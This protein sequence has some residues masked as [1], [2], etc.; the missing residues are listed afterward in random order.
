MNRR[1]KARQL[2]LRLSTGA[3]VLGSGVSKLGADEATA[4]QLQGFAAGTYPFLAELPSQ[5]FVRT[6]AV[7]E[8]ALGAALVL[9]VVPAALA[10]AGLTGFSLGLLGLYLRTPGV[11]Q[12]GSLRP[13]EQRLSLAKDVWMLGIGLAL[14]IDGLGEGGGGSPAGARHVQA[15]ARRGGER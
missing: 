8:I 4:K 9:P 1:M 3:L 14:V 11:R 7:S 10:G 6:L 5:L 2:P 13:T 12:E 15:R